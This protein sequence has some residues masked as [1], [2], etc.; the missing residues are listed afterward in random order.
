VSAPPK[1]SGDNADHLLPVR[2]TEARSAANAD[3]SPGQAVHVHLPFL[4]RLA[5]LGGVTALRHGRYHLR[6]DH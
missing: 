2:D 3:A 5:H 6:Q 4:P 1:Q